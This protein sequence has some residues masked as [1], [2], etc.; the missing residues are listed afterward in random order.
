MNTGDKLNRDRRSKNGDK[1]KM[2]TRELIILCIL[3]VTVFYA[4]TTCPF[5]ELASFNPLEWFT[6]SVNGFFDWIINLFFG[7]V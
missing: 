6:N 2:N 5:E 7:W 1:N 4:L 3:G